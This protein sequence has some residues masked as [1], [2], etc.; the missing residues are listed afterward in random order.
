MTIRDDKTLE[1]DKTA[2]I[3]LGRGDD[4]QVARGQVRAVIRD[5]DGVQSAAYRPGASTTQAALAVG[6][7][8]GPLVTL[9]D[10]IVDAPGRPVRLDGVNWFGLETPNLDPPRCL[11]TGLAPDEGS[12]LQCHPLALFKRFFAL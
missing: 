7:A 3:A 2:Y 1:S 10:R 8:L 9:N 11:D 5:D 4:A 12:W 6:G